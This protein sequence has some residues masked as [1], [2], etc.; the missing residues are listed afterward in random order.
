MA[1]NPEVTLQ[2][3]WIKGLPGPLTGGEENNNLD[4]ICRREVPWFDIPIAINNRVE[5]FLTY[6]QSGGRKMFRSWLEKSGR[7]MQMIKNVLRE[8]RLP[9]DLAYLVL[10]ESGFN[11][12]AY[13]RCHASGLWQFIKG[14]GRSYGLQINWWVDERREPEKS[15]LAAAE[16]LS[17]LYEEFGSWYLAM[18]GYNAGAGKLRWAI[19]KAGKDDYWYLCKKRLLRRETR[20][21]VPKMIAAALIAKQPDKYG[22]NDLNHLSPLR[23]D[24]VEINGALSLDLIASLADTDKEEIMM[25]NPGLKRWCTPPEST[26]A[27]KIPPGKKDGFEKRLASVDTKKRFNFVLHRVRE[28]ETLSGI[29][30]HYGAGIIPIK[31]F[32]R[33]SSIHRIRAGTTLVIP[34]RREAKA[35]M[36]QKGNGKGAVHVVQRG[37]TLWDIA[38]AYNISVSKLRKSNNLH[39]KGYIIRPGDIIY[40]SSKAKKSSVF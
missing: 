7:Y 29:A 19:S 37:D 38:K 23:Y 3:R 33:L 10:I 40:L 21:Y 22:F 14:T 9:E 18:A 4:F 31:D 5:W 36:A 15:T 2:H 35:Y 11:V 1:C 34:V 17:D 28:G 26:Y 30:G 8:H 20:N 27:L 32:N 13:S 16:H 39:G 6:F 12:K 25:L 24:K